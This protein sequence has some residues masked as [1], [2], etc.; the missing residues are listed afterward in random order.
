MHFFFF[1]FFFRLR[2]MFSAENCQY[3]VHLAQNS[4][5]TKNE[6]FAF[7]QKDLKLDIYNPKSIMYKEFET[8]QH[9]KWD[10]LLLESNKILT[11]LI[12]V[13]PITDIIKVYY[14]DFTFFNKERNVII[15][16]RKQYPQICQKV[17]QIGVYGTIIDE[18]FEITIKIGRR[19]IPK[20]PN[21]KCWVFLVEQFVIEFGVDG[22][23]HFLRSCYAHEKYVPMI[24]EAIV[25][26]LKILEFI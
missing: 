15:N 25:S 7:L 8:E 19:R 9:A 17:E 16:L 1:C 23:K 18:L 26:C 14:C 6:L 22:L 2:K 13:K 20:V 3:L 11:S 21:L 10:Q 12:C 4:Y 24:L 5:Q